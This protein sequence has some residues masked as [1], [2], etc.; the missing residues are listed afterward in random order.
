MEQRWVK[1]LLPVIILV[2]ASGVAWALISARDDVGTK[3]AEQV[4]PLVEVL[5]VKRGPVQLQV[6]S[7]GTVAAKRHIAWASEVAG[8]VTW[9]APQFTEG[10]VVSA[11]TVLLKLE[12]TDYRVAL[13]QAQ[14]DLADANLALTE[15]RSEFKRGTAYKASQGGKSASSSLRQPKLA[16]VEASYHAAQER[17]LQAQKDLQYTE[18]KAPYEGVIDQKQV[19][20]GQYVATGAILFNLLGT[21]TVEVRLPVTAAEIDFI[22]AKANPAGDLPTVSLTV[23]FGSKYRQWQGRLV[24]IEQ[25]VDADTRT[26]FAVAEINQPYDQQVHASA[27]MV[28]L[29]V[30]AD[31]EGVTVADALRIPRSAVHNERFVLLVEDGR[32][33]RREISIL[34]RERSAVVIAQGLQD[35][36]RVVLSRLDVMVPGMPVSVIDSRVEVEVEAESA[37]GAEPD[38]VSASVTSKDP[39][40]SSPA[41]SDTSLGQHKAA[42][43]PKATAAPTQ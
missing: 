17:L 4:S 21:E 35:G 14:A 33:Q 5:T 6:N 1:R 39:V 40:D 7:Q 18:I 27:L 3:A 38:K 29:F 15:E 19:D 24:R 41:H 2:V 37:L 31:I 8:R 12:A 23:A 42:S 9:V 16:Q 25:R 26:F 30:D 20:L 32:L 13:A 11:G 36:D 22:S 34:R 28:G 43:S 10:S